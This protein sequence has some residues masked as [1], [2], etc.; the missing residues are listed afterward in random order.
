MTN[1]L[2]A[3]FYFP[4]FHSIN[5]EHIVPAIKQILNQCREAVNTIVS[6]G[7]PYNWDNLVQ[8][9]M[10]TDDHLSRVFS[11]I[12]H[13]HA[14][15]N[16]PL[17][18]IAYEQILPMI[19]EYSTW[20]GQHEGLHQAYSNFKEESNNYQSL[21]IAQK[22]MI[23]NTMREFKMSGIGL[24]KDKKNRYREISIRLSILSSIYSNNVLDATMGWNKLIIDKNQLSGVPKSMIEIMRLQAEDQG[25][26]GWLITL[27]I[28]N[29]LAIMTYCDQ[30]SLREE[31]Y[32]AYVTR[33]SD[34]GPNAGKWDN[35]EIMF[36]V[37]ELRD[38]LAQILGFD[39]YADQS[40]STKMADDV[41][42]VM[43]FLNS[44]EKCVHAQ[45][46]KERIQLHDFAK[47]TYAIDSLKPWDI[48]FISEKQ[49]QDL[50]HLAD[51]QIRLYFPEH[52]VLNGLFEIVNRIYG[53]KVKERYN[54]E[55]YHKDVR[56]FEIFD[57]THTLRGSFFLDLYV[58]V[59]KCGGAWMDECVSQ[60]RRS[61]GSLQ[62]PIAYITCNFHRPYGG[63]TAL[64][65]HDEVVTLFH[66]FG[67]GLHHML[68]CIEIRGVSG[69]HGVP[70]DAVELPSQFMENWCWDPEVL[71]FLSGHYETCEPLPKEI[72]N[73]IILA[74][75]YQ[76]ALSIQKQLI[77][78][79]FDMRLHSE[80]KKNKS[81]QII[82]FFDE[83]KNKISKVQE[84]QW[85]R[86]PH[87]FNHIFS[88]GY[89]AGYYSYLWANVLASDAWSRFQIE[90]IFNQELGK[91]FLE[92]ILSRGGSE[93][94]MI[95]LC[96]FLGRKPKINAMLNQ[97]GISSMSHESNFIYED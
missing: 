51:E 5:P 19:S 80:F 42:Q 66:E 76:R 89:A 17:L 24:S 43:N 85:S 57:E 82:E 93:N 7:G 75:N 29:Y 10:E 33:A 49:K 87:T 47:N 40:L 67:H 3:S 45:A 58:R 74:K 78:S 71:S 37:L 16:N 55:V 59:N 53:I 36:E 32:C 6:K 68:T 84:P 41:N 77:L 28:T 9:L 54:I 60:M 96:R 34:Q 25:Q 35:T 31:V 62:K 21:S 12:S 95:L 15:Q 30:R 69:I 44:L 39:S 92:H 11:P 2:L 14:V 91:L 90:G 4:P 64:F 1:P 23:D 56:F 79:L 70:W 18:R 46:E 86:F 8:P 72:I 73:N 52:R 94:P 81:F 26:N 97:Y 65:T 83:I 63:H 48:T 27:D 61:D 22:K 38:E 20:V 88:G 13:L 50:Y